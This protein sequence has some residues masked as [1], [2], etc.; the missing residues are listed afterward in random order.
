MSSW[1][2]GY[3]GMQ[4]CGSEVCSVIGDVVILCGFWHVFGEATIVWGFHTYDCCEE[5]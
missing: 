3:Y 4:V 5:Y 2:H 1:R